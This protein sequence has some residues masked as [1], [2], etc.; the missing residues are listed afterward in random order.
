M[1][2]EISFLPTSPFFLFFPSLSLL[3]SLSKTLDIARRELISI[4]LSR[5]EK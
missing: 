3:L 1:F 4:R 2:L 5:V